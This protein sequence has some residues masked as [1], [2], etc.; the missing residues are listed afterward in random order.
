MA[1]YATPARGLL[2]FR[3]A[4]ARHPARVCSRPG[5][6]ARDTKMSAGHRARIACFDEHESKEF[7]ISKLA[8][9]LHSDAP[10]VSALVR[11]RP[12][13]L[14]VPGGD[15]AFYE[16]RVQMLALRNQVT[17]RVAA[18]MA[19]ADPSLLFTRA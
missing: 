13:L 5:R 14:V 18:A 16:R 7:K 6:P 11:I 9:I 15:M 4:A 1:A 17:P 12:G 10:T 8:E 3:S 19:L 2:L